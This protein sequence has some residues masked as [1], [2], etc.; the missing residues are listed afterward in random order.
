MVVFSLQADDAGTT[1]VHAGDGIEVWSAGPDHGEM[2]AGLEGREGCVLVARGTLVLEPAQALAG[3][4]L[5]WFAPGARL[6]VRVDAVPFRA[7]YVALP[8]TEGVAMGQ[9]VQVLDATALATPCTL[10]A[11]GAILHWLPRTAVPERRSWV[12]RPTLVLNLGHA[13]LPLVIGADL[14]ALPPGSGTSL[15]TLVGL[16]LRPGH[17]PVLAVEH[18]GG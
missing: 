18:L 4:A 8:E 17:G 1:P 6:A 9:R 11:T 3:P 7:L 2:P 12:G 15:G 5:A 10:T 14:A 13:P 16:R